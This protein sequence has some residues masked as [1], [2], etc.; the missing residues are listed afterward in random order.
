MLIKMTSINSEPDVSSMLAPGADAELLPTDEFSQYLLRSPSEMSS[1]F[2]DLAERVSQIAMV[3]NEGRD[4]VLSSLIKHSPG[5]LILECGANAEMNRKALQ[6]GK[7]FCVTH[8]NKVKIQFIVP[9]VTATE[10]AGRPAFRATWPDSV[11]RLQRREHYRLVT[12]I[13]RPLKCKIRFPAMDGT[14]H[15]IEVDIA[16]ISCGGVCLTGLPSSLPLESDM[17]FSMCSIELPEIGSITA[18]L[19]L[20]SLMG[21]VSRAGVPGQR[22]GCQFVDLPGSMATLIQRYIIKTERER[23]ARESGLG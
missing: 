6:A 7:L 19:R 9:G 17:E 13:A 22:A 12:P 14:A 3:F 18:T 23:K 2:R 21:T 11:L 8:L 1:I 10:S 4:M 20:R 16:D 5:S 15:L